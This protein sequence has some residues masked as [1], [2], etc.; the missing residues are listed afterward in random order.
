[1]GYW[2]KIR[3]DF[4][5]V[6]LKM[7]KLERELNCTC[8]KGI[9]LDELDPE[10]GRQQKIIMPDCDIFCEMAVDNMRGETL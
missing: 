2:N 10:R 4:P 1:M 8:I 3:I 9:Y 6:F 7:T 5:D